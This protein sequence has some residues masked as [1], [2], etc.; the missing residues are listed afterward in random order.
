MQGASLTVRYEVK[1]DTNG[2]ETDFLDKDYY[3]Y[4]IINNRNTI[5]KVNVTKLYDYPVNDFVYDTNNE[6][7]KD[8]QIAEIKQ[9]QKGVY[10]SEDA[11]DTIKEYNTVFFTDKFDK[12]EPNSNKT[13]TLQLSKILANNDDISL[14]NGAEVN[15]LRGSKLK[16]IPGNYIP[17]KV[18]K[19]EEKESDSDNA[20]LSVTAPTGSTDNTK[21]IVAMSISLLVILGTGVIFIKKK[22][23]K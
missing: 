13:V 10:F 2:T 22:I 6:F 18:Y 5:R 21:E 16:S 15:V 3:I 1:A 17:G 11:Y 7:N 19:E 9:N 23:L 8:W 12:I 4:G 20:Y 14:D